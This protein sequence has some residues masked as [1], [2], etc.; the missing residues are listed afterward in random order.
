MSPQ[1]VTEHR[2]NVLF[3]S[4]V[5]MFLPVMIAL[6]RPVFARFNVDQ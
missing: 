4:A 5:G 6:A 2:Y 1:P 3:R